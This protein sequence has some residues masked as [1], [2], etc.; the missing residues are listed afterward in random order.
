MSMPRRAVACVAAFALL[1]LVCL[2]GLG[3]LLQAEPNAALSVDPFNVDARVEAIT[4][5]L[6]ENPS[7]PAP[8]ADLEAE[9]RA[10][11]ALDPVDAR[12]RALLGEVELRSNEQALA[13]AQ[14]LAAHRI[15]KTEKLALRR[16][17]TASLNK[18]Q[19][20]EAVRYI[21]LFVRRWRDQFPDAAAILAPLLQDPAAYAEM[22]T[23]LQ[24]NPPWRG[25]LIRSLVTSDG[26]LPL[27]NRLVLD[28]STSKSPATPVE[29]RT[30]LNALV[31][32][33]DYQGAHRLFLFTLS[34]QDWN[35]AGLV[36]NASFEPSGTP[37]PFDWIYRN[38]A[39]AYLESST[40]APQDGMNVRFLDK[41]AREVELRQ[42]LVLEPGRYRLKVDASGALLKA[43]KGLFWRL[44][45]L[46]PGTEI[47]RLDVA[48]GTYRNK[49]NAVDFDVADC[50]A[51]SL[52]L[53]SGLTIDSWLYRY[54]GRVTFHNVSIERLQ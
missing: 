3:R 23:T 48:E 30:V 1:L 26:G 20:A 47:T 15:S 45:C 24:A 10:A 49:E 2:G 36:F 8:L 4:A 31:R 14:F 54:S 43:P 39:A 11:I 51:Q 34:D 33:G 18:G 35:R 22:L 46:K 5:A 17:I 21:D 16:L 12:L 28:L 13:E 53:R 52:E 6:N 29:L 9:T 27:A 40:V 44:R 38:T 32:A 42:T 19:T 41:P 37:I 25:A 7:D 50:P